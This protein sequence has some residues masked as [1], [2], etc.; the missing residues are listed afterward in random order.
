[1]LSD[2]VGDYHEYR[3]PT[4]ASYALSTVKW[5][6][7]GTSTSF[8]PANGYVKGTGH[9]SEIA[10]TFM[11]VIRPSSII[12][13]YYH[14]IVFNHTNVSTS[15]NSK[16]LEISANL[17]YL[18]TTT[19]STPQNSIAENRKLVPV[20]WTMGSMPDDRI[21]QSYDGS[22]YMTSSGINC[23]L[24]VTMDWDEGHNTF[25]DDSWVGHYILPIATASP[26]ANGRQKSGRTTTSG[27]TT[28]WHTRY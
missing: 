17:N 25:T 21:N 7:N 14:Q 28:R 12:G 3:L 26:I 5:T 2:V 4:G 15:S 19:Y 16:N 13:S 22:R 10:N 23:P 27:S 11:F 6:A 8:T 1:M 24:S 20:Y 18:G 9:F